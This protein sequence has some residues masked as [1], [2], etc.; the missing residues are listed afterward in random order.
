MLPRSSFTSQFWEALISRLDRVI[1]SSAVA[2][3]DREGLTGVQV[4]EGYREVRRTLQAGREPDY[5]DPAVVA[6]YAFQ[7]LPKR[8]ASLAGALSLLPNTFRP[9]RVLDI[10]S[11]SDATRIA[12]SLVAPALRCEIIAVE[13]S[14]A[15]RSYARLIATSNIRRVSKAGGWEQIRQGSLN[16]RVGSFDLVVMSACLPYAASSWAPSRWAAISRAVGELTEPPAA[17]IAIQPSAKFFLLSQLSAAFDGTGWY[18][19]SRYCCHAFPTVI[20]KPLPLPRTS[21]LLERHLPGAF[22][23]DSWNPS[24][25]ESIVI[26]LEH[27]VES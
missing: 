3:I 10:G 15:M 2:Y 13:P 21:R 6:G 8:V 18:K 22:Y 12:L 24:R 17:V 27:R 14:S 26:G 20:R 19:T 23:V 4:A 16:L 11:G 7:Y 9:D 1:F 25:N 5:D